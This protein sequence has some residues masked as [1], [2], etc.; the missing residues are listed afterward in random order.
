MPTGTDLLV[1]ATVVGGL[2][3]AATGLDRGEIGP[4]LLC[5]TAPAGPDGHAV[6]C[7]NTAYGGSGTTP[8]E[9]S[10]ADRS[11]AGSTLAVCPAAGDG[12][13]DPAP[14][15][16][17]DLVGAARRLAVAAGTAV[18]PDPA[19][20]RVV[21]VRRYGE[22]TAI[23]AALTFRVPRP[24]EPDAPQPRFGPPHPPLA[25][26]PADTVTVHQ[27]VTLRP[28]PEPGYRPVELD[29]GSGA[30]ARLTVHR[31]D[32][33]HLR[34]APVTLAAR[35]RP[36]RP[37][38]FTL[39]PAMPDAVRDAV[40]TGGNRWAEAFAAAGLPEMFRVE[41][42]PAGAD[43]DDPRRNVV[44]W[45]HRA[46]RG[47]SMGLTQLDPRTGEVLRAVVRLGSHR[48]EQVRALAEAVLAPYTGGPDGPAAVEAVV[49]ARLR[50]LAAHEIGHGLGFAHNFAS[51]THSVPSV[52]DY[53]A[54]RFTVDGDRPVAHL[55]YAEQ[56]GP[57]DHHQVAR[58]YGGSQEPPP[59]TAPTWV[60]D[61]D[62]RTDD[63]AD[64]CGAT[65]VVPGEPL[66]ALA[67]VLAVRSAA[68]RRFSP[69]VVPPGSDPQEL[70]RRFLLLQL[71]HRH[72]A[73]AVA[74]LVGGT[75]RRYADTTTAGFDGAVTPVGDD[76]Q[77]AALAALAPLLDPGQVRVPAHVRPL[78]G[79][80][81][82]RPARDGRFARRTADAFDATAAV[83]A[84]VD[85]VAGPLLAPARLNRVAEA[86]G[87]RAVLTEL[88]AVTAGHAIG[89]L[90]A[91]T[92]DP[93][94]ETVGWTLLRRFETTLADPALYQHARIA[95]V[96]TVAAGP[97][98]R[99]TTRAAVRARWAAIERAAHEH[100][101]E[102]PAPPPGAPL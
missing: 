102:L 8:E 5:R 7:A 43:L 24:V 3:L 31:Y 96:E 94:T 93:C 11:F 32:R 64:A 38:V 61:A 98:W 6:V 60:T 66:G 15:G 26:A 35:F 49:A 74:K 84:A 90:G 67:E 45:V 79:P 36:G 54:P 75:R 51:H 22:V 89:L 40:L 25:P 97:W 59:D 86:P 88:L 47:W 20:S 55:P 85:V 69:A 33:I 101:A 52:M 29:P 87:D 18:E 82:G 50:Q 95:A 16:L 72:Q 39:D 21:A 63:A 65:W 76:E 12:A 53:P 27:Q 91:D 77:L 13:F 23:E 70:E 48:I 28:P 4:S 19:L 62:A 30:T 9:R 78:P 92:G 80:A 73:T 34:D 46:D 2:G 44:Y 71:L 42:L 37:I 99:D 56:L 100:P 68:L 81:A 41:P 1:H 17:V 57:W 14:L 10:A 58:L 83:V